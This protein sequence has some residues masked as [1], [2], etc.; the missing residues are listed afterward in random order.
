[1]NA[2]PDPGL[3]VGEVA[4]RSAW[5]ERSLLT[6][7]VIGLVVGVVAVV[8]PFTTA[9]LF[10]ASLATAAWPL[11]QAL[12]RRARLRRGVAAAV[13]LLGSLA[14]VGIP[15]FAIAPNLTDQVHT[16]IETT[17]D[18][19]AQVPATTDLAARS[20]AI[21]RSFRRRLGPDG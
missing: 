17:Q 16:A 13:L 18:F 6:L 11:R 21:R 5:I 12:I 14:F 19:F 3:S 2:E 9:I 4:G 8:W 10:G 1:M 7:L 15:V 20:T